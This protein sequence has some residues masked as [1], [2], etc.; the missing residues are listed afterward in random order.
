MKGQNV[1]RTSLCPGS[2]LLQCSIM[3]WF[4]SA[5]VPR[6]NSC[7]AITLTWREEDKIGREGEREGGGKEAQKLKKRGR[8]RGEKEQRGRCGGERA[9]E[10]ERVKIRRCCHHEREGEEGGIRQL[11][12]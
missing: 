5:H 11:T 7:R 10:R 1:N 8:E 4:S 6:E 2:G 3:N 9:R 12:V